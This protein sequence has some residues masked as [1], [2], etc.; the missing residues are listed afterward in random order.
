M[1]PHILILSF[2]TIRSD[3][4]VM[5][6]V[7]L[8]ETDTRLIVAGY[9]DP[10]DAA[11]EFLTI[12]RPPSKIANKLMWSA[13]LLLGRFESYYWKRP[14]VE[15]CLAQ[16]D[17]RQFDL[18]IANDIAA[19]PLALRLAKNKPVLADAHEYSPREFD[20]KLIWRILFSRYQDYL[21]RIYLPQSSG[22]TTVCHGIA[23]AYYA[24][25]GVSAKV[26]MNSPT[27]QPL[28]PSPII[29]GR[30]RLV[31]HGA[32]I[33]SRHLETM[34][35]LMDILDERF[36]LDM[37]LVES[38]AAYMRYL[39]RRALNNTRIRFIPPV[40]MD[41]IC[42]Q[43]NVYDIG[44]YLLPPLNFNHEY[45]LPNKLFEFI[46]ARLAIAIGPS[47]EMAKI[48]QQHS[49][50]VVSL[51][52]SPVDLA[53]TLMKIN[54]TQLKQFKQAVHQAASVLNYEGS[55]KLLS[56]EIARLLSKP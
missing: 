26:V 34:I 18:V 27:R 39:R 10:P 17:L 42:T 6:Q 5:R 20:D 30:I 12:K 13:K 52:F 53:Q 24:T 16:L 49:L 56:E 33:R 8:L 41:D 44:L 46:Q 50:G 48:V 43:I 11:C 7:R 31:H 15:N 35:D 21:C 19:L 45:A 23:N 14:E 28:E 51:S 2:S 3:P 55:A 54:D 25:Y 32:A 9:G 38:D 1:K 37:M 4:R 29:P 36:S 47:P 40:S 22:M